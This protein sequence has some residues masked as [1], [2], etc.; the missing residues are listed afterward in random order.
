M[1][2]LCDLGSGFYDVIFMI[3]VSS[4]SILVWSL[5][6][7]IPNCPS[8]SVMPPIANLQNFTF[9]LCGS[10][11][12]VPCCSP[13][14]SLFPSSVNLVAAS[15]HSTFQAL[16]PLTCSAL[17][18]PFQSNLFASLSPPYPV[19]P[20]VSLTYCPLYFFPLPSLHLFLPSAFLLPLLTLYT[21]FHRAFFLGYVM[22]QLT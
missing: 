8:P 11:L 17:C 5:Q 18:Q 13:L 6:L 12:Q 3:S 15:F 2:H 14:P 10:N 21:V 19:L 7:S 20:T 1:F 16:N 22:Y 9:F 4:A